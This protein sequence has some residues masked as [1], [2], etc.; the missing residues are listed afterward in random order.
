MSG[1]A[2]L[3][4]MEF[5]EASSPIHSLVRYASI[6]DV[7]RYVPQAV[8]V[9]FRPGQFLF[10]EGHRPYGFFLLKSGALELFQTESGNPMDEPDFSCVVKAEEAEGRP[11][12]VAAELLAADRKFPVNG[13]AKE[14]LQ[15]AFIDHTVLKNPARP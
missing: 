2:F 15:C 11:L 6:D 13:R 9:L 14:R 12:I 7:K 8:E 5:E 3:R 4:V 1:C 10:Y